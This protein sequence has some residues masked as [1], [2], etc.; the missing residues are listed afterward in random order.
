M[1]N[2]EREEKGR[3]MEERRLVKRQKKGRKKYCI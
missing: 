1:G 3:Q 2:E